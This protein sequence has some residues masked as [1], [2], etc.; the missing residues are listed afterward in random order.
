MYNTNKSNKNHFEEI[1]RLADNLKGVAETWILTASEKSDIERV[2]EKYNLD[3]PYYYTDMT[4]LE[5]IVRSNPGLWLLKDGIVKGKW[6]YSNIP[7]AGTME[8]LLK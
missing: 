2:I 1:S 8:D 4:V 7:D 3:I 5:A 6:P